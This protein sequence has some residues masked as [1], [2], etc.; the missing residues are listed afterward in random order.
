MSN[1][2]E[3]IVTDPDADDIDTDSFPGYAGRRRKAAMA[4]TAIW[5]GTLILHLASWGSWVVLGL[6]LL[7]GVHAVRII[8]TQRRL[9][10]HPL[11]PDH[12]IDDPLELPYVSILVAA[13]N[14]EAVVRQLV[15]R[16][17]NLDYPKERYDLWFVNDN[18]SDRT[19]YLLEQLGQQY[20]QLHVVH[21]GPEATGGKSG[22]LNLVWPQTQG[23]FIVVFDADAK[24]PPDLLRHVVPLFNQDRVGAVQVRK[25][26][27]NC[28]DNFWTRGQHAEM[29]LDSYFQQQ[30]IAVG[31]IGELRGN[32]QF[33]R[34]EALAQCGGWNEETLT[35]DLDLTLRLHLHHWDIDFFLSPP[36]QEEGVTNAISLWHQRNRWAEGGYQRYLDY[37]RLI[38]QN[39]LGLQKTFDLFAF[40][41]MQY[42]LPTAAL[43]DMAFALTRNHAPLLTPLASMALT[44]STVGMFLGLRRIQ[45]ASPA[46][47]AFQTLRGTLYMFHWFLVVASITIRLSIRPKR[48][49]WVKTTHFGEGD[50]PADV[51]N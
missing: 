51:L 48:L 2:F 22:A 29:A 15:T 23:E 11:P 47:T 3:P 19:P 32:G 31:G 30:R 25:E 44:C 39:R 33:V 40:W 24:V 10:Y 4:L 34:R 43:P 8:V 49:K 12:S 21:R 45:Q 9:N 6:T 26:I 13:K 37:W 36:V 42:L 14:E 35:D 7:L 16:L 27:A 17:C 20:D 1:F 38:V 18:S 50:T 5:G 46:T 28:S 41:L